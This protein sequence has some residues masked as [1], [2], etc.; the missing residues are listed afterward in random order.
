MP[1]PQFD[2]AFRKLTGHPWRTITLFFVSSLWNNYDGD[3]YGCCTSIFRHQRDGHVLWNPV[4]RPSH[5][6]N[7]IAFWA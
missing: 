4:M 2:S 3:H 1:I 6:H 5:F 7:P